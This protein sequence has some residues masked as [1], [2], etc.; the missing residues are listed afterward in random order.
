ND[1]IRKFEYI[2]L[3]R[4]TEFR[5]GVQMGYAFG[6]QY[7]VA[8]LHTFDPNWQLLDSGDAFVFI[9]NHDNQRGHGGGSD[10]ILTFKQ[11]RA[12]RMAVAFIL[13]HPYGYPRVMSSY[14]FDNSDQGPPQDDDKNILHVT[15]NDDGSCGNGWV[16][17]HRWHT[18]AAMVQFRNA[19]QGTEVEN[20]WDDGN[21]QI[22]F[23]RGNLG[24]IAI[25]VNDGDLRQNLQT[26]L[27]AGEYCDVISGDKN[28]NSCTGSTVTVNS[29][30]TADIEIS[31]SDEN[32]M[33]AI[34]VQAKLLVRVAEITLFI[35]KKLLITLVLFLWAVSAQK[36]PNMWS[37]RSTIVHLFEWRFDDI[38]DECE[39]FLA[40]H[41]YGGVQTSPVHE[42]LIVNSPDRPWW[43]RYQPMSYN[44]VSRSGDEDAFRD[45]VSRCNKV[46]VRIY[47]DVLLNHMTGDWDN[48][49]GTGGST[50]DTYD[51]S[52]PAVPYDKDNF[53]PYC[54]LNTYNDANVIRNCELSG[55]HDLDQS[56]DY[57][58]QK[59]IDFLN[60]LVD[61]GVAGFRVDAAKHCWP[62]D[63]AYVYSNVNDLNTEHGFA[64]GSRPFYYQEVIDFDAVNKFE[65]IDIGRVTEF[66]HGE[67]MCFAFGGQYPLSA[68]RE[69]DPNW[70]LVD[71]GD[72]LVFIDN[73]DNQRGGNNNILTY[74]KPKNYKMGVAFI[75]AHTYG[76]PRV[77]S[78][79]DFETHDQGPP[80]DDDKNILHVTSNDDGSCG[81][82][83]VCEHRWQAHRGMVGFRNVVAGTEITNWWDNGN[84][85]IA[86]ARGNKG[87][88]A[89]MAND[90]DLQQ[91]LQTGLP[92]GTYC[93]VIT[94]EKSGS[95][96]TGKTITVNSDGT[97]NI[98]ILNSDDEGVIAIHVEAKLKAVNILNQESNPNLARE[99]ETDGISAKVTML[100]VLALLMCIACTQS[101]KCT[102]TWSNRSAIVHLFE[103]KFEDIAE[104]CEKFL[105]PKGFAAV[106]VSPVNEYLVIAEKYRPWWERY[107]P[108]SYKIAS[109]S[110][111][112]PAFREMVKRCNHVGV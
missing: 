30:G 41:G 88:V 74:K 46:G 43:E 111:D 22:A 58:R 44:I 92:A 94:G 79:F 37:N 21:G 64:A 93:D 87:F 72:A 45:M 19:I 47:V 27:P 102:N 84:H 23:S 39:N 90:S 67:Q 11:P 60:K 63:L 36:D 75:L 106:Q 82:G 20:W 65:Y 105:A 12:Y 15:S 1:A 56:Q 89:F 55:L 57:V 91:T 40:P 10:G 5:H 83:W 31:S 112:E 28:G 8:A 61:A 80:Q 17:E 73:H 9:D 24:F 6:G 104:E 70:N 25:A 101:Q 7:P 62:D 59:Q 33:L 78:S 71:S 52:Y 69:L 76:S 16:C 81:N 108:I 53:H 103:W 42:C 100:V 50:A 29:D 109:R 14:S 13:A 99:L 51:Y 54:I 26:G 49:V 3:G 34:H 86:F 95:S 38:A 98:E 107:Q 97:A 96:C 68:L 110:G 48:A 85:Q 66:K 2:D 32:G 35:M 77:M 4:V 18:H